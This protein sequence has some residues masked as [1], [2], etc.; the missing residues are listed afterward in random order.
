MSM[1]RQCDIYTF[2]F[3]FFPFFFFT[4]PPA[5]PTAAGTALAPAGGPPLTPLA[6]VFNMLSETIG[7]DVSDGVDR[8]FLFCIFRMRD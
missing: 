2:Y 3:F 5:G 4:P 8:G 7:C 1:C 6:G